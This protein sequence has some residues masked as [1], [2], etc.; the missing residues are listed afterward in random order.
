MKSKE[1]RTVQV[2]AHIFCI[3][4]TLSAL[5]PFVLLI[6]SSFTDNEW[7]SV[8]G[9]SYFPKKWSLEAYRY[10]AYQ[11][12]EIGHAYLMSFVVTGL[13]TLLSIFITTTFAYGI[14]NPQ[15][16]GMRILNKALV[17]TMLFNGG[18]V[19][20][21]YS[22]VNIFHVK[23]TLS[24]VLVPTLVMSAFNVILVRNYYRSSI[25][26]SLIEAARIDGAGGFT[27]FW[28]IVFPLSR[29]IV[30]TI[31]LMTALSYWNDWQNGFYYLSERGGKRYY[32]IQVLLNTINEN[33][34]VLVQNASKAAS[35]GAKVSDLPST[36][37]R[38][39]IAVIGI[40]PVIAVYPFFQK[41]FVKGITLGGVKE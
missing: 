24:A 6:I 31:G 28:K 37:I 1:Y 2:I 25:P 36:T 11:W 30:A 7:A 27:I 18:L 20:T 41:Y 35:I 19:A 4:L 38:M 5:M 39:A 10:I 22:Y 32:T 12:N 23:N 34:Q 13:G 3:L 14:N 9:Y 26:E 8:Y 17:F 15:I 29:P 33:I 16:P 21:Y 40:L